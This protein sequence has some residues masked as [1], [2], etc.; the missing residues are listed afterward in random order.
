MTKAREPDLPGGLASLREN[1]VAVGRFV[2]AK[3]TARF[4][5]DRMFS[6][7]I[8]SSLGK[9]YE[10]CLLSFEM[11]ERKSAFFLVPALR[12]ICEDLI[13]LGS[14]ASVRASDREALIRLLMHHGQVDRAAVQSRFFQAFRPFQPVLGY[15]RPELGAVRKQAQAIWER[16]GIRLKPWEV[17]PATKKL[18]ERQGGNSLALLYDFLYRLTSS[19]VHFSPQHLLR[20]GW[21]TKTQFHFS[22]KNFER[23]YR[24]LL[25]TYGSLL[26]TLYFE[27]FPRNLRASAD[28]KSRVKS[29][30]LALLEL[31]RWPELVTFEEMN[32]EPPN[33]AWPFVAA[34]AVLSQEKFGAG[35]LRGPAALLEASKNES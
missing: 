4:R 35:F 17:L 2:E 24:L 34:Q 6:L 5:P 15:S 22:T 1:L 23:Y 29:L 28:V 9:C 27:L 13:V 14:L 3:Q 26:L 30:R 20:A 10:L 18:A 11:K 33:V 16:L 21:G 25:Q 7:L 32:R 19:A 12:G 31:P 8:R